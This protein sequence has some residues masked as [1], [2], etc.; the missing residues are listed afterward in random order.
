MARQL[1]PSAIDWLRLA[2][3]AALPAGQSVMV[4]VDHIEIAVF[5]TRSGFRAV[6]D[7]CPHTG[8]PLSQG[9]VDCDS[10]SCPWHGWRYSLADGHREDRKGSPLH[11]YDVEERDGWIWLRVPGDQ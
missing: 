1:V 10:V 3:A 8:G 9:Q 2:P 6:A 4:D 7:A 11:V 5:H